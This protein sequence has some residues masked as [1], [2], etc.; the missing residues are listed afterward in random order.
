MS[1]KASSSKSVIARTKLLEAGASLFFDHSFDSV[2]VDE[3][4]NLAGVARGLLFHYFNTKLDFYVEV[5]SRFV[6]E[7]HEQRV[8]ATASGSPEQRLRKFIKVHMQVFRQRGE[9]HTNHAR[10]GLHA[11]IV[12]VSEE[13]RLDGV[14]LILSFFSSSPPP[15]VH[16][17]VCRAWLDL[18]DE[19]ILAWIENPEVSEEGVIS[20]CVELFHEAMGRAHL[21]IDKPEIVES[22]APAPKPRRKK[23]AEQ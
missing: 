20:V 13:S 23:T 15:S 21:L 22:S 18:M 4:S 5:Y 1:K 19:L 16:K 11:R 3:I 10:G 6:A 2:S 17:L 8:A 9:A 12:A 14:L 7:L